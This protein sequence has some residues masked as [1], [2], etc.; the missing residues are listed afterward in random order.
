[1]GSGRFVGVVVRILGLMIV[2]R[3]LG[4]LGCGPTTD[5]DAVE[6]VVLRHQVAVLRRRVPRARYTPGRSDAAGHAGK[7]AATRAVGGLPGQPLAIAALASGVG[8][9]PVDLPTYWS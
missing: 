1:M 8:G 4:V 9:P 5:A 6:I 3:V 2:R 7:G